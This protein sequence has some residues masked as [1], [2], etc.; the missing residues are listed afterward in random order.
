[1]KPTQTATI[2]ASLLLALYGCSPG[3]PAPAATAPEAAAAEIAAAPAA[4]D[5]SKL[6]AGA[7]KLDPSHAT[8]VFKVNHLGFSNYTAQVRT[9]T[10]DMTLDPA[11]PETAKLTATVELNS[12]AIPAPP[13]GFIDELLS[14]TWLGA[15]ITPQMKFE[16]TSITRTGPATADIVGD[17]T[18][19]G[20]TKPVTLHATFNGGYEG[21]PMDPAARIGFSAHGTLKRSDFGIDIG[22]PA[23]GSTM[24]VFDEVT[25]DIETEFTGPALKTQ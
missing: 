18:L 24:G 6:P 12:L 16:S 13:A 2:I 4:P 23:P 21:H 7:Y 5:V 3:E 25:I 14:D 15:S 19:K 17:L 22:I 10:A 8:L 9:F 1:M 20:A 11:Q